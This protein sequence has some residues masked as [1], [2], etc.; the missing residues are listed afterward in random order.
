MALD[1]NEQFT[2]N[3]DIEKYTTCKTC[4]FRAYDRNP[5]GDYRRAGCAMY[6]YPNFKPQSVYA[7]GKCEKYAPDLQ[8]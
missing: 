4:V 6:P 1:L 7:G 2:N 3:A 8:E 5:T